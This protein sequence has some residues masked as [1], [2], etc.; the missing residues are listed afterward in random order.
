MYQML[1]INSYWAFLYCYYFGWQ[2]YLLF[3]LICMFQSCILNYSYLF[4][5]RNPMPPTCNLFFIYDGIFGSFFCYLYWHLRM[6][7]SMNPA[8]QLYARTLLRPWM[9]KTL[10]SLQMLL[11]SLIAWH[12]W[13]I[14]LY[15]Y[16]LL[17]ILD[18]KYSLESSNPAIC[19]DYIF[20]PRNKFLFFMYCL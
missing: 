19:L 20:A 6:E 11:R 4:L 10:R 16:K 7:I 5:S 18:F 1:S 12:L 17:W 13:Y 9:R 8:F 2:K 15:L 14:S 3:L